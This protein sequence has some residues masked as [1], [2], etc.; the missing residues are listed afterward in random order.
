M[1]DLKIYKTFVHGNIDETE[2]IKIKIY[3]HEPISEY[4][5]KQINNMRLCDVQAMGKIRGWQIQKLYD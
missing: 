5:I 4:Q 1:G 2:I 3:T